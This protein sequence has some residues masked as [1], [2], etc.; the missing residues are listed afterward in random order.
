M[1]PCNLL[2]VCFWANTLL[3]VDLFVSF[4]AWASPSYAVLFNGHVAAT[5]M[6]ALGLSPGG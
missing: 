6:F 5:G 1:L 2:A 4:A 3:V